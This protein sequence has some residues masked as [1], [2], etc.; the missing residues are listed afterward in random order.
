LRAWQGNMDIQYVTD[1]NSV[2]VYIISYITQAEQEMGML[3]QRAQNEARNGNL[4]ARS[5]LKMLGSVYLHNREVSAQEAVYRLTGMHLKECSR[6][7]QF[8]PIGTDPV[9][10]SLPLQ[11]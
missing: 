6:K 7:V 3:L 10:M 1:A 8:I 2:V 9:K 11:R 4:E 5:S